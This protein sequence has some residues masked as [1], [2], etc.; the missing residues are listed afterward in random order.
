MRSTR[1]ARTAS[2]TVE[3]SEHLRQWTSSSPRVCA[4][5][6][7]TSRPISS[8]DTDR[9]EASLED[10]YVLLVSLQDLS[11]SRPRACAREGHADRQAPRHH[12]RGRRGRGAGHARRQQASGAR[13]T[14]PPVKAPGFG[15]RRKAMLQDMAI[16]TGGQVISEEVGLKL[17]NAT[18]RTARPGQASVIDHQGRDHH[19]RGWRRQGRRRG[20][21]QADPGRDRQHRLRLRP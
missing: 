11:G 7:A 16:L 19:R 21:Y 8:T 1:S 15:D 9:M 18:P 13:S 2:I 6:R 12:R 3:E 20:S 4:S 14:P 17:E 5:T 10:P